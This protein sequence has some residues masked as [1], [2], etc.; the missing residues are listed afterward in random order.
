M[1]IVVFGDEVQMIDQ[2][3]GLFEARM[4]DRSGK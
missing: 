3:H 4:R 1:V 2:P